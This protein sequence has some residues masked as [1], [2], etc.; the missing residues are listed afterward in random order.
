MAF[1]MN[2]VGPLGTP[3]PASNPRE[4][5]SGLSGMGSEKPVCKR[6]LRR[7]SVAALRTE[8]G[9]IELLLTAPLQGAP[10]IPPPQPPIGATPR[11]F[12]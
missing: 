12:P 10:I 1:A 6:A 11:V 4:A 9:S 8:Q 5:R 7:E 2:A 3:V